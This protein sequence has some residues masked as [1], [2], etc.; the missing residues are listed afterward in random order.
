MRRRSP[1]LLRAQERR[2]PVSRRQGHRVR[3]VAPGGVAFRAAD[4]GVHRVDEYV[5][6]R[7]ADEYEAVGALAAAGYG[8]DAVDLSWLCDVGEEGLV[9]A[10]FCPARAPRA[11]SARQRLEGRRH[12]F[13]HTVW[14]EVRAVG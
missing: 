7:G 10:G 2:P 4:A 12:A 1:V 3:K 5:V 8:Q 6:A 14:G 9:A 11:M 13:W